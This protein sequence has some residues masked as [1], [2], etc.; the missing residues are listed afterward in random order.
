MKSPLLSLLLIG[1]VLGTNQAQTLTQDAKGKSSLLFHG[2]YVGL[3]ILETEAIIG[4]NNLGGGV[5]ASQR[6]VFGAELRAKNN[7]GVTTLFNNGSPTPDARLRFLYGRSFASVKKISLL[8]VNRQTEIN[9]SIL[10][11][12]NEFMDRAQ[13]YLN[14]Q[15]EAIRNKNERDRISEELNTLLSQRKL[16]FPER[17]SIDPDESQRLLKRRIKEFTAD[18]AEPYLEKINKLRDERNRLRR[19]DSTSVQ[20]SILPYIT[21]GIRATSFRQALAIDTSNFINSFPTT[22]FRGGNFGVGV[23][24]Q[25]GPFLV[26]ILYNLYV[27]TDNFDYLKTKEYTYRQTQTKGG[28]SLVSEEKITAYSGDYTPVTAQEL[29]IDALRFFKVGS[30]TILPVTLYSRISFNSN[31]A[32][33]YPNVFTLGGGIYFFQNNGKFLG[34]LYVELPDINNNVE[35]T[36]N[37]TNPNL[38]RSIDRFT[39]GIVTKFPLSG[40]TLSQYR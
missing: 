15:Y 29:S 1:S 9:D 10:L 16:R 5:A 11:L 25:V 33:K 31:N 18:L 4:V 30:K 6:S 14:K 8:D 23:N 39:L 35:R 27:E 20:R 32:D 12:T 26:G 2:S 13:D 22:Y 34:G 24:G 40:I 38:R 36:F 28:S 17:I 7:K 21:G 37:K 3:N 19:G